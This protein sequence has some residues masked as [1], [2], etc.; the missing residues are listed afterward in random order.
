LCST[1]A[2]TYLSDIFG[3]FFASSLNFYITVF[4]NFENSGKKSVNIRGIKATE[5]PVF[6]C[7]RDFEFLKGMKFL[8]D[9]EIEGLCARLDRRVMGTVTLDGRIL[10]FSYK[11][12][13]NPGSPHP[14]D[15]VRSASGKTAT[16]SSSP[17]SSSSVFDFESAVAAGT[18]RGSRSNSGAGDVV[19]S[20]PVQIGVPLRSRSNTM[21]STT[22]HYTAGGTRVRKGKSRSGSLSDLNEEKAAMILDFIQ[23]ALNT[24]FPDHDFSVTSTDQFV[25]EGSCDNVIEKVNSKMAELTTSDPDILK[26]MWSTLNGCMQLN[27]CECYSYTPPPSEDPFGEFALWSYH[28]F[29]HSQE[30]ERLCYLTCIASNTMIRR[31]SSN[32]Y[33]NDDESSDSSIES[34]SRDHS[35]TLNDTFEDEEHGGMGMGDYSDSDGG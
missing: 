13:D 23:E 10:L 19:D 9:H 26:T 18:G 25:D 2:T 7:L 32:P 28:Y 27:K 15:K 11:R 30:L 12:E 8:A 21:D 24:A 34:E 3:I 17:P 1:L 29:F 31:S 22:S 35:H 33:S 14:L 20:L 4:Q 16:S 6:V 5:S